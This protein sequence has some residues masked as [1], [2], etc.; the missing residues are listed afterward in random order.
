M[1]LMLIV[2][3]DLR[4]V[5]LQESLYLK[6]WNKGL[7]AQLEFQ[8]EAAVCGEEAVLYETVTNSK[9]LPIALLS[10]KFRMGRG[11]K[12]LSEE[13]STVSDFV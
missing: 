13:N 7:T 4:L 8:R 1:T 10:V 6:F 11:L 2:A 3:A 12:F 5:W 9:F